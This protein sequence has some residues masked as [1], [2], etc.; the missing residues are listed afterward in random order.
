[1]RCKDCEHS[2]NWDDRIKDYGQCD[3]AGTIFNLLFDKEVACFYIV[4]QIMCE[5]L[6]LVYKDFGCI[7]FKK[8]AV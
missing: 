6:F 8:K 4:P 2:C 5:A 7:G 1:M 3:G